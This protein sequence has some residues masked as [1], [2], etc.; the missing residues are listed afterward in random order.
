M[1]LQNL[2]TETTNLTRNLYNI[3][4]NN[5]VLN[6]LEIIDLLGV[7]NNY[8]INFE[9]LEKFLKQESENLAINQK[10][11]Q[12]TQTQFTFW[13]SIKCLWINLSKEK[14]LKL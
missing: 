8:E 12:K 9:I 1:D 5:N 3:G 14:D 7:L 4:I 2:E 6:K 13:E 10:V 11:K